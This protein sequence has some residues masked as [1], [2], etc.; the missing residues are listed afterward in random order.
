LLSPLIFYHVWPFILLK[1]LIQIYNIIS[2]ISIFFSNKINHNK[3]YDFYKN[4]LNKM[5]DQ[6]YLKNSTMT[7]IKTWESRWFICRFA[8]VSIP[9]LSFPCDVAPP[10]TWERGSSY[11]NHCV[12]WG[13]NPTCQRSGASRWRITSYP[14]LSLP[15]YRS[16]KY[17]LYFLFLTFFI[18]I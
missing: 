10:V 3:I 14:S 8:C 15:I 12:E 16:N 17:S 7:T 6:M 13:W 18:Y 1:I 5:I 9:P 11:G 4:I 2:S